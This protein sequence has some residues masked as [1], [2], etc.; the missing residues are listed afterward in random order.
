MAAQLVL[1]GKADRVDQEVDRLPALLQR[2]ER[3]VE[4][5]H[6]RDVA[7]EAE[8]GAELR[9]ERADALLERFALVGK[10][11]LRAVLA[12]LLRDAPGE[13][14]LVGEAHDQPALSR[15]QPS[16]HWLP[17]SASFARRR[18]RPVVGLADAILLFLGSFGQRRVELGTHHHP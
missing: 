4:R 16:G 12:Q 14:L 10:R 18:A 9:G 11:Q 3:R 15:H 13:R 17:F 5:V 8:V 6:P 2:V 7:I 1:V